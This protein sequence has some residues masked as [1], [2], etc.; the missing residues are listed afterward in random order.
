MHI[1]PGKLFTCVHSGDILYGYHLE[2]CSKNNYKIVSDIFNH[3]CLPTQSSVKYSLLSHWWGG[4]DFGMHKVTGS[5]FKEGMDYSWTIS[6]QMA[7]HHLLLLSF[8]ILFLY[9]MLLLL[10]P[11]WASHI[12][13][14]FTLF[15]E[16]FWYDSASW[17]FSQSLVM[18][19]RAP[20]PGILPWYISAFLYCSP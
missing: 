3:L 2:V 19:L 8:P 16:S 20:F 9:A 7:R 18:L 17:K 5:C 14:E 1:D 10:W 15:Y 13:P 4:Y 12:F 11:F 6:L